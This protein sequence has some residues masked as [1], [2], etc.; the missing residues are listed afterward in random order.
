VSVSGMWD[1]SEEVKGDEPGAGLIVVEDV[2][3]E[4]AFSL[5]P[6]ARAEFFQ[7]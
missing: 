3:D 5:H 1:S 7:N 2:L 6:T 4:L